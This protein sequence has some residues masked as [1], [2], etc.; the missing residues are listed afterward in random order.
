M[1]HRLDCSSLSV[2]ERQKWVAQAALCGGFQATYTGSIMISQ[3]QLTGVSSPR[4]ACLRILEHKQE[5]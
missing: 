2:E 3:I 4:A 5:G 1:D